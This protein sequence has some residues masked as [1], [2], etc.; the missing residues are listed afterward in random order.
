MLAAFINDVEWITFPQAMDGAMYPGFSARCHFH[1]SA[2]S[3]VLFTEAEIPFSDA[4]ER[5][6]PK[7]RAE[8]LA[9]RCLARQV[10]RKLGIVDF[11]LH[12][13][14]DR[15][16]Q[17]PENIAGSLSHNADS[18]LC[19]A[20]IRSTDLSCVGVDI[21]TFLSAERAQ[22]LW[23]GIVD[24]EEYQWLNAQNDEF[25]CLLT[26]SFSAKESLFKAL[27]PQVKRYFDFL[28]ARMVALDSAR[29]TFELELQTDLTP[30]FHAGRRFRGTFLK[31]SYDIATF[32]CC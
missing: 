2:Y 17:W 20:H 5:S 14:E 21:E 31:R 28:D 27:Y 18:V 3:D 22:A 23:P 13:G 15:S 7:R 12:S 30:M 29:Q 8:F 24:E 11:V 16:P 19:A 9:G 26:L 4:L 6:V 1:L 32:L 10:V 25:R